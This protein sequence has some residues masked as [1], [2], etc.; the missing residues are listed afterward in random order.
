MMDAILN[1]MKCTYLKTPP[2]PEKALLYEAVNVV[3]I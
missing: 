3:N 2:P 1:Q